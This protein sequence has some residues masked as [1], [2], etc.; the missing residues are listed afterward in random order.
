MPRKAKSTKK[1]PAPYRAPRTRSSTANS[2]SASVID[3]ASGQASESSVAAGSA[4][5][6]LSDASLTNDI[7]PDPVA[8]SA[9]PIF[10]LPRELRD[11]IYEYTDILPLGIYLEARLL[12]RAKLVY[13]PHPNLGAVPLPSVWNKPSLLRVCRQMRHEVLD[14]F[15]ARNTVH[16]NDGVASE[17]HKH[18][19]ESSWHLLSKVVGKRAIMPEVRPPR[20]IQSLWKDALSRLRRVHIRIRQDS[21]T[22]PE[23]F[24]SAIKHAPR[25]CFV[26]LGIIDRQQSDLEPVI[27]AYCAELNKIESLCEVHLSY[28]FQKEDV[29]AVSKKVSCPVQLMCNCRLDDKGGRSDET[30]VTVPGHSCLTSV[31]LGCYFTS[32]P[33]KRDQLEIWWH[34]RGGS[35]TVIM[36]EG[37]T[38]G[39][40]RERLS[41]LYCTEASRRLHEA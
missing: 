6:T 20:Q 7:Y 36:A 33:I 19:Q 24:S 31:V 30:S 41:T 9:F 29:E 39:L 38:D 5:V 37:Y 25:L 21:D 1:R 16:F 15:F 23:W 12:M 32:S 34:V 27:D 18:Y 11:L 13:E 28:G 10:R 26:S 22:K 2:K 40:H 35:S 4:V 17:S 14:L 3:V 8:P